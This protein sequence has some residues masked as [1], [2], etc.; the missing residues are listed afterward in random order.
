MAANGHVIELVGSIMGSSPR[1]YIANLVGGPNRR[2]GTLFF[3]G[4]VM[5]QSGIVAILCFLVWIVLTFVMAL[6]TGWVHVPLIVGVL[7]TVKAIVDQ[8]E[9]ET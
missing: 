4:K 1:I 3:E 5:N 6:P 2:Q 7:A 8:S 9:R